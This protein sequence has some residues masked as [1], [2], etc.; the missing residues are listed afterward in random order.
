MHTLLYFFKPFWSLQLIHR[1]TQ[2]VATIVVVVGKRVRE[3]EDDNEDND[4]DD[5][6]QN[7]S[8]QG[9]MNKWTK[10]KM[11]RMHKACAVLV[12]MV[13]FV[14]V[15]IVGT[16]KH[17]LISVPHWRVSL[18]GWYLVVDPGGWGSIPQYCR[19]N[20]C[21]MAWIQAWPKTWQMGTRSWRHQ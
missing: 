7:K 15:I 12:L 1:I 13:V 4:E 10:E 5:D 16:L 2:G 18:V 19:S 11:V 21:V 9:W 20:L 6:N 17:H 8:K 14:I 3:S